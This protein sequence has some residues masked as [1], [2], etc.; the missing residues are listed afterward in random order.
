MNPLLK[1]IIHPRTINRNNKTPKGLVLSGGSIR[2]I[3]HLGAL[4]YFEEKKELNNIK[5]YCGSSVGALILTLLVCGYTIIDILSYVLR[6]DFAEGLK[7][8]LASLPLN[9]GLYDYEK[10][11]FHIRK[12]IKDKLGFIPTFDE[13]YKLTGKTLIFTTVNRTKKILEYISYL[14]YPELSILTAIRMTTNIPVVFT[15]CCYKGNIYMDGSVGNDFPG[16]YLDNLLDPSEDIL[17]ILIKQDI[18]N[19]DSNILEYIGS[20]IQLTAVLHD[21]QHI[22]NFSNR[23]KVIKLDIEKGSILNFKLSKSQKFEYFMTGYKQVKELEDN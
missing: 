9:F 5:Y 14:N 22:S 1:K 18:G 19:D 23:F 11:E 8:Q 13:L 2:G 6:T 3:S 7:L 12:L 21:E 15:K 20:I 4:Y 16:K 17:G 10:L